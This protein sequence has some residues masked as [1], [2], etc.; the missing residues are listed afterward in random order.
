MGASTCIAAA[1][2]RRAILP[3]LLASLVLL[4]RIRLK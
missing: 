3:L 1:G 4:F 2:A